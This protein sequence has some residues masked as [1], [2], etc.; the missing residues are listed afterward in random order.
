MKSSKP[1]I[2]KNGDDNWIVGIPDRKES[3]APIYHV[4]VGDNLILTLS[5]L[6]GGNLGVVVAPGKVELNVKGKPDWVL[7]E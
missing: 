2:I 1:K 3:L 7:I 5:I 6:A 4:Y